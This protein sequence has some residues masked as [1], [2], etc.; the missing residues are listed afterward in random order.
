MRT[1]EEIEREIKA[2]EK[3]KKKKVDK[4]SKVVYENN[5]EDLKE[6]LNDKNSSCP[7]CENKGE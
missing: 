3:M 2:W 6:Q 4:L 7:Y 5:I 1:K